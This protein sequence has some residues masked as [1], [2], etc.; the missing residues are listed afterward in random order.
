MS[1][2][3][4]TT[5]MLVQQ[6]VSETFCPPMY[7]Q[8]P[9]IATR[10]NGAPYRNKLKD[11]DVFGCYGKDMER[12]SQVWCKGNIVDSVGDRHQRLCFSIFPLEMVMKKK[13]L[14]DTDD[15]LKNSSQRFYQK[16]WRIIIWLRCSP[17]VFIVLIDLYFSAICNIAVITSNCKHWGVG[18]RAVGKEEP[19]D[20]WHQ[21][22]DWLRFQ[23]DCLG[24]T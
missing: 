18:T 14:L 23:N 8:K 22:S 16:E 11:S 13:Q 6:R 10:W 24:I 5:K 2:R 12:S 17:C 4:N 21:S 20:D 15:L 1:S 19:V 3:S 9:Q 7:I